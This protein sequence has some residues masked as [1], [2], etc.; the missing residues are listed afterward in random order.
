MDGSR[1]L[2]VLKGQILCQILF[3]KIVCDSVSVN[4]L[5]DS[6]HVPDGRLALM[7]AG[8]QAV[9]QVRCPDVDD[10]HLVDRSKMLNDDL[11]IPPGF[12]R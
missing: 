3:N 2:R 8:I 1:V 4:A 12:V 11:V 6:A 7:V 5:Q 9:L 10:L